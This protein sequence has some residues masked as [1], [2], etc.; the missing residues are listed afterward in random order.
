MRKLTVIALL[1]IT[2]VVVGISES[3]SKGIR[4]CV[5][6]NGH[7]RIVNDLSEC[8]RD[9]QPRSFDASVNDDMYPKEINEPVR[10]SGQCML[11]I[12]KNGTGRGAVILSPSGVESNFAPVQKYTKGTIVVLTAS[13]DGN[14]VFAGWK[15]DGCLGDGVCVLTMNS[16]KTVTAT[17]HE[18]NASSTVV[19]RN[20][21]K[22]IVPAMNK[23]E[24][25]QHETKKGEK[26][27]TGKPSQP[28]KSSEALYAVQVGAFKNSSYAE[29]LIAQLKEKGYAAYIIL[30]RSKEGKKLHKVCIGKFTEKE[31]AETLSEK[32]R[33]SD[34]LQTF[35]TALQP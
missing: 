11:T 25:E 16:D 32:I 29:V 9:E 22:S 34:G 12:N 2:I 33:N 1:I 28:Q 20:M 24:T 15:G 18:T 21:E 13:P 26:Q 3:Q 4:A 14:S 17:F 35:V 7:L 10:S 27:K 19:T 31:K 8:N 6:K 23:K 30:S 5:G